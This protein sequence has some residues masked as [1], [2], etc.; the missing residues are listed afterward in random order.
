MSIPTLAD[1]HEVLRRYWGYADFRYY[2][3]KAVLAALQGRDCLAVL[4]T[5]GGKSICY[6]VPGL[7][8]PGLTLVVSPLISLMQDQVRALRQRDVP[9]A[10]L[11]STQTP[12]RRH[13]VRDAV[14]EGRVRLLYVAPERLPSLS[15]DVAQLRIALLAVD[16]AHCIS[17]WG[18]DFRPHYR[19]IGRY[20]RLLGEP[21]TIA[22]TGTA[23]PATRQDIL[24]V[25]GLRTPVRVVRSHD[26]PNLFLAARRFRR[27]RDRVRE[28]ASLLVH[29]NGTAIVYVPTR[30]RTD[31]VATV[32]RQ[33]GLSALPY[34][35]GLPGR[36]RR[37]LLARFLD[38]RCRVMVATSAFGMGIDKPDVRLVLHLGVPPR[39]E[40]YFQEAG[41]AGRD[42]LPSRCE[43]LWTN[44][45]LTLASKLAGLDVGEP[46]AR[47][48]G[49]A[50]R[51]GLAA[52]RRYLTT[53]GCRRRVLLR[54]L[55]ETVRGCTGCDRC[56][57]GQALRGPRP[58]TGEGVH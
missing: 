17:E 14:I 6:Q 16:E 51:L 1:A 57:S 13:A 19:A 4:P 23:T 15:A 54:Y 31:G 50:R 45:D 21:R 2:Q 49:E 34:H 27:E 40:S 9:A 24:R 41:R 38:G 46:A 39:P 7:L 18:H 47:R 20:R 56:G 48:L 8:L 42:G 28:A 53:R 37:E 58:G 3:R 12:R 36:A 10:Y 5:G 29:V 43:V 32:L 55:G 33:W 35:A 26:R 30:D 44:G 25:L 22:V 52:M 11:S